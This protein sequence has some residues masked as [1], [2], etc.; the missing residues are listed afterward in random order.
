MSMPAAGLA[1]VLLL[2]VAAMGAGCSSAP[3]PP[4]YTQDELR[5]RCDRQRG[6]WRADDLMGGFCEF[7]GP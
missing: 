4:A 5:M 1:A 3:I 7:R 6:V 2:S